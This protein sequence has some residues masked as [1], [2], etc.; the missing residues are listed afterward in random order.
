MQGKFVWH[1]LMST[2][3]EGSRRF[4]GEL[5]GWQT[6]KEEKGP[7]TLILLNG[8]D[9][10]G[11]LAHQM[12]G[13]PSHW[14]GYV[15]VSDVDAT[16][17]KV[18]QL[19]GKIFK[20]KTNIPNVGDFA[21]IADGQGGVVAPFRS[22]NPA[23]TETNERPAAYSFCWDELMTADTAQ[24]A[25][26]YS[27]LFGWQTQTMDMPNFG[28]YTLF[29]RPGTKDDKGMVKNAGGMMPL[30]PGVPRTFWM[31][32]VAVENC[33]RTLEKAKRLGAQIPMP[34]I[35]VE[36]VGRFATIIDP[37]GAATAILQP[38]M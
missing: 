4:Y 38:Q 15:G 36:T 26:F 8:K 34:A 9:I 20:E 11:I 14:L 24:A 17:A 30:P 21:V 7:Y 16:L 23:H 3:V 27:T 32:Y 31:T 10:G 28:Q 22:T 6:K 37:Q 33:D 2:D 25:K 18:K 35:E 29:T 5:F 12:P 13:A 1:D 19:G